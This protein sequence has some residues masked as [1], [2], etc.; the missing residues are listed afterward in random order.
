MLL[1]FSAMFS[2]GAVQEAYYSERVYPSE[3]GVVLSDEMHADGTRFRKL[4]SDTYPSILA[5]CILILRPS[6]VG[7]RISLQYE[8]GI[9]RTPTFSVGCFHPF[10]H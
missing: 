7:C 4:E 6:V 2:Q 3:Q 8:V 9:R 10:D 1:S 5:L